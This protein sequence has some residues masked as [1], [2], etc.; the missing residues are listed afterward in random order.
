MVK[1]HKGFTL[2][3]LLIVIVIISI[4]MSVSFVGFQTMYKNYSTESKLSGILQ[5]L[6]FLFID[7]RRTAI[8]EDDVV[9]IRYAN[10][11]FSYY[12]DNNLDGT[13]DSNVI[14]SFKTD[15][16]I[17]V[18]LNDE[19]K[20]SFLIYTYDSLF[21]KNNAGVFE[22]SYSNTEIKILLDSREKIL[23]IENSLPKVL[24]W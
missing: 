12:I 9:C 23:K 14:S 4:V 17:K 1:T 13:P 21:F 10:G 24:E 15:E 7:A 5:N 8:I 18:Y 2:I 3:E 6:L 16:N 20:S 11:E 22:S 19:E